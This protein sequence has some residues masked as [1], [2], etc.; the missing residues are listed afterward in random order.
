MEI[1]LTEHAGRLKMT[2]KNAF[3]SRNF[4]LFSWARISAQ[5]SHIYD[6][7]A[8]PLVHIVQSEYCNAEILATGLSHLGVLSVDYAHANYNY[9]IFS[10]IY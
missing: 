8:Y 1:Y 10:N 4:A 6:F 9:L 7:P 3:K 5:C 2:P